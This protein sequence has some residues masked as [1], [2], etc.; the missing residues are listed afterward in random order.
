MRESDGIHACALTWQ[1]FTSRTERFFKVLAATICLAASATG[2]TQAQDFPN[3]PVRVIIGPSPDAVPRV[4]APFLQEVWKQPVVVESR[5]GAGGQ[6]AATAV[7]A[8]QPDGHMLL[9]A[10][11]SY[12]LNTALRTANYDVVKDFTAAALIGTGAYTLVVHPSVPAK[13]VAELIALAKQRPGRLNCA[14]AGIGTAPHLACE[15]F[16]TI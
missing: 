4:V 7:A 3:K 1:T 11:P 8:A 2:A 16:N 10:T 14:S 6:I 5:P 15:T 12:T 9:F 13:N